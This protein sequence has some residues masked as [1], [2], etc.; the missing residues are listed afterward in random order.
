MWD[1]LHPWLRK[2]DEYVVQGGSPFSVQGLS[3]L[4]IIIFTKI[5]HFFQLRGQA[6]HSPAPS[7][8]QFNPFDRLIFSLPCLLNN[9]F[10][11]ANNGKELIP[12]NKT[13]V[14]IQSS[15]LYSRI[16]FFISTSPH[17]THL[18]YHST[19]SAPDG[20]VSR[21][22]NPRNEAKVLIDVSGNLQCT[23]IGN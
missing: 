11:C 23:K 10:Y 14:A 7:G 1:K 19:D 15:S 6:K 16:L 4:C 18:W 21:Q 12:S 13:R 5:Y 9:K 2:N 22:P 3:L 20:L 17:S 8:C